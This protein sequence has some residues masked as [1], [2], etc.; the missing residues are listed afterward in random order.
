MAERDPRT[1]PLPGDRAFVDGRNWRVEAVTDD[2]V[3]VDTCPTTAGWGEIDQEYIAIADVE[4]GGD[5][6]AYGCWL[7][8]DWAAAYAPAPAVAA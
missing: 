2:L 4:G 7:R 8:E 5:L 6:A 3:Y 1:N